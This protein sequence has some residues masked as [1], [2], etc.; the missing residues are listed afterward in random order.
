MNSLPHRMSSHKERVMWT[1]SEKVLCCAVLSR[2]VLSDSLRSHGLS[3]ARLLCPWGFS[4]QEYWSGL[5][6]PPLGDLPNPGIKPRS[7]TLPVDSLL[8]ESPGKPKNTGV[9]S[10]SLLRG[11]SWPRNWIGVFCLAGGFFTSWATREV[12]R[13]VI[14][15][16]RCNPRENLSSEPDYAGTLISDV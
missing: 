8:S 10:L 4:R 12:R 7:R 3:P 2:S 16:A 13:W 11:S 14:L 9:G 5:P 15:L 6:C 1:H